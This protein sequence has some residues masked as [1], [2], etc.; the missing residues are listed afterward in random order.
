MCCAD[1]ELDAAALPPGP[2][3]DDR[4]DLFTVAGIDAVD[5]LERG[6]RRDHQ[7]GDHAG[8]PDLA[9]APRHPLAEQEDHEEGD[10]RDA[11]I[12]QAFSRNQPAACCGFFC[13]EQHQ[14]CISDSSSRAIERRLR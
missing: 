3:L 13:C 12:S 10:E 7:S 14:P 6:T 1:A 8:D 11:G 2:L 4:L 5:P 9:A